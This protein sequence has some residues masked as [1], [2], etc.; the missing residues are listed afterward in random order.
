MRIE[1]ERFLVTGGLGFLGR[2][3]ARALMDRGASVV[4]L[5]RD[6]DRARTRSGLPRPA[7]GHERE[8]TGPAPAPHA[9]VSPASTASAGMSGPKTVQRYVTG[10][11]TPPS[12]RP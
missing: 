12:S 9:A 1:G 7:R 11:K 2:H 4:V 8:R 5:D 6:E 3:L 10:S